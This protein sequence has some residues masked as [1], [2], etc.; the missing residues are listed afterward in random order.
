[1]HDTM[2]ELTQH[3]PFGGQM[4]LETVAGT[5][6]GKLNPENDV[7]VAQGVDR[8]MY[9]YVP[10]SGVPHAKQGQVLMVLRDEATRES[11]LD[12]MGRLGLARL[13][14]ERHFILLF[15]NPEEGGWNYD[16]TASR[17]DDTQFLVRCF[18]ALKGSKGGVAG[19]N[20]MIYHLG[21]TPAG[22]AMALTLAGVSP[23]DAAAVMVGAT[24]EGYVLPDS[25]AEQ[26]AWL[27]EPNAQVESHLEQVNKPAGSVVWRGVTV[28]T[29]ADNP[30]VRYFVSDGGLTAETVADAWERMF[31]TTRRWRNDT[32]G[33]Y[34][35]RIDFT[36][37]GFVA[38]VHDTSLGLDDGIARTWYEYVPARLRGTTQPVPLVFFLHGINCVALYSAEQ[39]GWAD[40]AD[41]DGFIV[42]FPDPAIEERWNV[43]DDP[44]IPSDVTFIR[45][46][47]DHMQDVHPIDT[48][49]VYLSG[50]SM[51]SMFSN[52]LACSYPELFAGAVACNGPS[53]G[54]LQTL[55]ESVPGMLM[56]R[57]NSVVGHL[58]ATDATVP[59]TRRLADAKKAAFD[60]RMPF[61]QFVGLLDGVGLAPG[62]VWPATEESDSLWKDDVS[63][64]LGYD[65]V[66]GDLAY[67]DT[68]ELGYAAD[69]VTRQGRFVHLAWESADEGQPELF[70]LV[71]LA[72]MPH[73]VDLEAIDKGWQFVRQYRRNPDGSLGKV[74]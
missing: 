34:Q 56:F 36:D 45:A 70:H 63:Y 8:T 4:V 42:V 9:V 11:A 24:P 31:S 46:L 69:K 39:S 22:S 5:T 28:H 21:A 73:A 1:M 17:D 16:R 2:N 64:W 3:S 38:H 71:G 72:R 54:Y 27:Y 55:D 65:N 15:P 26:V 37:R 33:T 6:S 62:K 51:G 32:Y 13:A 61:V 67:T 7:E 23:L 58:P 47:I 74:E 44:R 41:R 10:G 49:R 29:N 19:F 48:T 35:P 59:P 50:F 43:W 30:N 12:L 14:E 53:M 40:L 18:A 57:R 52:A 66:P 68:N 25:S 20:G 60:Y